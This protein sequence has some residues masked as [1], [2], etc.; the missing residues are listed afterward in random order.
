VSANKSM[1]DF[2]ERRSQWEEKFWSAV[3]KE[4]PV[5]SYREDL[6]RCWIRVGP[7]KDVSG[8][9]DL[10]I[11][12][13]GVIEST[14]PNPDWLFLISPDEY[15][16]FTAS[17]EQYRA[18]RLSYAL[19]NGLFPDE[20][21]IDHLCRVRRCVR[22]THLEAVTSTVNFIRAIQARNERLDYWGR[23]PGPL[24]QKDLDSEK[25]PMIGGFL[26]TPDKM[27]RHIEGYN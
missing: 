24:S 23:Y 25:I 18:H 9:I 21:Q 13:M 2:L 7:R 1:N 22:P 6:D 20:L 27:R 8:L 4:G 5:P 16:C 12:G 10:I 15:G 11:K 26:S 14:R 17:G 3:Q 19:S